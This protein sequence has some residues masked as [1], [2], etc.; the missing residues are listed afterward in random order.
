MT[1]QQAEGLLERALQRE[2]EH[3][4]EKML[5]SFIPPAPADKDW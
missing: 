4:R 3:K 2:K 1:E 5:R